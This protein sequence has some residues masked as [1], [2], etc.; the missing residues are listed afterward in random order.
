MVEK[1][2]TMEFDRVMQANTDADIYNS[3]ADDEAENLE[4]AI[5]WEKHSQVKRR[6]ER[7]RVTEAHDKQIIVS[8]W[9]GMEK[10]LALANQLTYSEQKDKGLAFTGLPLPSECKGQFR[11]DR[12]TAAG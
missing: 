9:E 7:Q 2:D 8:R 5:E 3:D 11:P 12:T 6:A 10:Y 1:S 4:C